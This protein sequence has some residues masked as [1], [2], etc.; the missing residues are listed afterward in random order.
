M[1]TKAQLASQKWYN[2]NRN[3][4]NAERKRKYAEDSLRRLSAI[5]K[6]KEY[7]L[8]NPRPT[9]LPKKFAIVCGQTVDAYRIGEVARR[10]GR[11]EQVIRIWE[12]K[13]YIPAPSLPGPQRYYTLQQIHLLTG[14]ARMMDEFRYERKLLP[15]LIAEHSEQLK[16]DWEI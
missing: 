3:S 4:F 8:H 13:G 6:Q 7:R 14:F 12:R 10:V 9:G 11:D 5:E 1:A 15:R 16:R 2:S